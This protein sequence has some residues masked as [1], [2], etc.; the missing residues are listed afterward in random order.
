MSAGL[1]TDT[2]MPALRVD[3]EEQIAIVTFDLPDESVNTFTRGVKQEF[4]AVLDRLE[5]DPAVAA[6]VIIS[7]K[8]DSFIAG[9]DIREF[10]QLFGVDGEKSVEASR[11]GQ[12]LFRR[13]SACPFVT[14][15]AID[16]VCLGGG[17]ELA[18]FCDR[19]VL[20]ASPKTSYGF[21]EVKLGLY[22]AWGGCSRLPRMIGLGNAVEMI[23]SGEPIDAEEAYKNGLAVDVAPPED[24]LS[25]AVNAGQVWLAVVAVVFSLIGAFYY[26]RIVKLMYFDEPRDAAPVEGALDMRVLLSANG[27]ALLVLGLYPDKLMSVCLEAM[28]F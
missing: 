4:V 23:T 7:G 11:R 21:P 26:L 9:A 3:I 14:V 27:L 5:N 6:A 20:S 16:G 17:A 28:R 24:L 18:L 10:T 2:A 12:Q 15:A 8:P 22:P 1:L 25:A 13:F 19:R